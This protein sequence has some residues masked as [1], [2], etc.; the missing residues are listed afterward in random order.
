MVAMMS[1]NVAVAHKMRM[2]VLINSNSCEFERAPTEA[3]TLHN[4][5]YLPAPSSL[6]SLAM[7]LAM[8]RASSSVSTFAICASLGFS[9]Q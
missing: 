6:G 1:A 9:R 7:L 5:I 2:R 8:R 3:D 4:A